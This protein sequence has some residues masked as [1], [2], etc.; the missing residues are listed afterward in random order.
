MRGGMALVLAEG[1]AGKARKLKSKVEK[2]NM[3]GWDWLDKLIAGAENRRKEAHA[4][5]I[6]P[7]EST[8]GILS[9]RPVFSYPMRKGGFRLRYGRSRDTGFATAG[10]NP[11]T[12]APAGRF[13]R[14]RHPDEKSNARARPTV[15]PGRYH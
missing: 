1:I 13:S 11:A 12:L 4:P 5:G 2:M 14:G 15:V 10:L 9:G 7:L 3:P 6:K 8:S